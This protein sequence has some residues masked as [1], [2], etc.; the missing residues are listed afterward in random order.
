MS[1]NSQRGTRQAYS[2]SVVSQKCLFKPVELNNGVTIITSS[3]Y[4]LLGKARE[5]DEL[6]LSL[7]SSLREKLKLS[8]MNEAS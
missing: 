5:G 4:N 2:V 3:C 1:K 6:D 8:A 7:L